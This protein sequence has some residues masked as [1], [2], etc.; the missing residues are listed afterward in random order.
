VALD[1]RLRREIERGG[2]PAD[3][4]GVYEDLIRRRERHRIAHRVEAGALALVVFAATVGG[5]FALTRIFREAEGND[6][7]GAPVSNGLIIF[8]LPL[9]RGGEPLFGVAPDGSDL[10]QLTPEGAAVY[11]SPDVSPDGSTVVAV[12][13]IEG[14]EPGRSMLATVPITGGWPTWLLDEPSVVLDPAWSPDGTRIAFAGSPGGPFG[15]Y[16]LDLRGGGVELVPGTDEIDV[17]DPTWSPD[18]SRIAFE[19]MDT[20]HVRWEIYSLRL[21]GSE[22]TNLTNTPDESETWPAWSWANDRIAFVRGGNALSGLYTIAPD[23][24]DEILVDD[25]LPAPVSPVWSPDGTRLAFSA[26]TGQV[27]TIRP[28][29]TGL[30]AVPGAL[31]E[32]A[33]QALPEGVPVPP[34]EPTPAPSSDPEMQ[35]IGL[36]FPVCN[37]TSVKGRFGDANTT[38][39]AYVA[40][41]RG[42]TGGCPDAT[43]AFNV[44]AVDFTDDGLADASSGPVECENA[45][46][47]AWAAPDV[48]GDGTDELLVQNVAFTIAGLKL[49]EV[50]VGGEPG[51]DTPYMFPVTVAPPGSA[52]FGYQGFEGG[53][54]PQFWLGGDA[55]DADAIRCEAFQGRRAFVSVRSISPIDAPGDTEVTETWFVLEGTELRIVDVKEFTWPVNDDVRPFLETG[56]CGADLDPSS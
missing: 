55:G 52:A 6:V 42:D 22:L 47:V 15:I 7:A 24:T 21:D 16:V 18:G 14:F 10:R 56:G 5:F 25:E 28:D 37:V 54:E 34:V 48:D 43:G 20:N 31:G 17:G 3:P 2:E 44:V 26:D 46:C 23:G 33:W 30:Q 36:G 13:E 19:A 8:S 1:E 35:D 53:T 39:V 4:S 45:P 49:F 38:G 9:E 29:G 11:R 50:G 32:P 41:R 12:H 27:Y 51:A 40:T